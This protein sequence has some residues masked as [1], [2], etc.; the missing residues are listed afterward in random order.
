LHGLGG[1]EFAIIL[2]TLQHP[3]DAE[4]IA[5]KII[6][7]IAET[8][9]IKVTTTCTIGISIGIAI[10]PDNGNE[11]DMLMNAAD[12]AMYDS[13]ASGK[14]TYTLSTLQN[15]ER[16]N[17]PW[18]NLDEIP[19][20]GVVIIDEQHFKIASMLNVMNEAIK[21]NAPSERIAQLLDALISFTDYHFKT[22]ER[23][24]HEHGY[25]AKIEHQ[26]THD[27]LLHEVTYLKTQFLKGGELVFLQKLRDWFTIHISSS[28]K[29]LADFI[30][31]QDAK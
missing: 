13:K 20:L 4:V 27:H 22:E 12:S 25:P 23:L 10:Y 7:N 28:D 31:Q 19:R 9:Q 5:Q 15:Q 29:P 1:D 26:N 14:N 3:L 17:A 2:N 24:M 11:I 8:I 18:I 21:H 30:L 6:N 16:S